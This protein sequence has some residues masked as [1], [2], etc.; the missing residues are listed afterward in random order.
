[1]DACD[2]KRNY[3]SLFK[4]RDVILS[5]AKD[6]VSAGRKQVLPLRYAQRQNDI[7]KGAVIEK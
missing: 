2:C 6:L 3:L 1:V 7:S 5:G 4:T